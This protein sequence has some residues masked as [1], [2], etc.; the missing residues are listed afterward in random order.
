MME[1]FT[2]ESEMYVFIFNEMNVFQKSQNDNNIHLF[3]L[4][5]W[6]SIYNLALFKAPI[7]KI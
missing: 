1:L 5:I 6:M 2:Y 4:M 7:Q 3:I